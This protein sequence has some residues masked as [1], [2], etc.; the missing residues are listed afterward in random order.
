VNGDELIKDGLEFGG[1]VFGDEHWTDYDLTFDARKV[2]GADGFGAGF[3]VSDEG[4]YVFW[5]GGGPNPRHILRIWTKSGL[6]DIWSEPGTIK[7]SE[8]YNVKI[9]LRRPRIRVELE[10]RLL[11]E[12]TNVLNP[13][14]NVSLGGLANCAVHFRNIKVAAPDGTVLW[15]GPPDLIQ[16]ESA[17]APQTV[18]AARV[19][20]KK[21]PPPVASADAERDPT[22]RAAVKQEYKDGMQ[23]IKNKAVLMNTNNANELRRK[24]PPKLLSEIAKKYNLDVDQVNRIIKARK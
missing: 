10:H 7:P 16:P 24:G 21:Q 13:K 20:T 11:L 12:L 14:G 18:A 23:S 8:W 1:V 17:P 6:K 19:D 4:N 5:V 2:A 3:H 15:E 22:V 9:S